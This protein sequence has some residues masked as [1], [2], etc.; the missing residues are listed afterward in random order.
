MHNCREVIQSIYFLEY[1][2]N[3]ELKSRNDFLEKAYDTASTWEKQDAFIILDNFVKDIPAL[4]TTQEE[5][6]KRDMNDRIKYKITALYW[7]IQPSSEQLV[8][9]A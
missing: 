8:S 9:G 5:E 1:E 3:E 4:S 2:H 6:V 7:L